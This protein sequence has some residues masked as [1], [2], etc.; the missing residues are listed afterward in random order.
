VSDKEKTRVYFT[1]DVE[2]AE[3]RM[4]R[5][6]IQP[7]LGYDLRVWGRFSNHDD[8]LGVP[9]IMRELES[10]GHRG[11][12]FVEP[13]GARHFGID[14]LTSVCRAL[15]ARGHDVQLHAHPVQ[16]EPCFRSRALTP[17]ND[18]LHA[19][20]V[21]GQAALLDEGIAI[22]AQ[23]GVP[24]QEVR[25]FRA[26]NFG[27]DNRTWQAMQQAGLNLSS[28][29]NAN[30]L[31]RNCKISWPRTETG[32]FDTGA[33]VWELPISNF[34]D[35]DRPRH[36]QLMAVSLREMIAYLQAARAHNIG[37]VNIFTHS[38]ELFY[39]EDLARRRAR[40]S[41][42]N[43]SRLRGLCRFLREH[44]DE[45]AVETCGELAQRLRDGAPAPATSPTEM[46]RGKA[47]HRYGR[48]VEQLFKRVESGFK[49]QSHYYS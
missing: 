43:L 23:A 48:M 31:N 26:G 2:C 46:P 28:N 32:L 18:N 45:F 25:A 10:H 14:G 24:R 19:R 29:L 39:I 7:A 5:G 37:E 47:L 27:A 41:S 21:A 40:L 35:G 11:T 16:K 15:R 34:L 49:V 8:E 17:E 1:V 38:F 6:A 4:E 12:F 9:L 44:A 22:L 42:L 3:E 30:Y 20:D 33:G 13:F 36:L